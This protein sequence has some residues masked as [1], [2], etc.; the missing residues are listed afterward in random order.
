[1]FRVFLVGAILF[2]LGWAVRRVA[3]NRT[4][5]SIEEQATTGK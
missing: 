3:Y 5:G 2:F 4:G 1:M